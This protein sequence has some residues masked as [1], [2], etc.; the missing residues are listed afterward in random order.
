MSSVVTG[1]EALL[2]HRLGMLLFLNRCKV[3]GFDLRKCKYLMRRLAENYLELEKY[4]IEPD[5]VIS[6]IKLTSEH[7]DCYFVGLFW[8]LDDYKD[9][10]YPIGIQ[11]VTKNDVKNIKNIDPVGFHQDEFDDQD[12][13]GDQNI[14]P[15]GRVSLRDGIFCINVGKKCPDEAISLVRWLFGI[16]AVDNVKVVKGYHWDPKPK[17]L[18]KKK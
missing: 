5:R 12:E 10:T 14:H 9:I 17:P 4:N 1:K 6:A 8:F 15:R 13:P 11:E 7:A 3:I 18:I 2:K 16:D